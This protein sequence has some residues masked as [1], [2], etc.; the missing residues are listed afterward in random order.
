MSLKENPYDKI[1]QNMREYPNDIPIVEGK[2]SEAFKEY[3]KLMFTPEEAE[4]AQHLEVRP[5]SARAISKRLGKST[6]ETK[7]ILKEMADNG[8]I[9]DIGGYSFFLTVAHL[10]NVGF[11]YSKAYKRLGKKGA[12]LYQQFFIEE[13][14]YKRYESSDTGT[15]LTRVIPIEHSI[16][17]K[18]EISNTEEIHQIIDNCAS[19]I[20]I[21]DCPC[22]K[23]TETLGIRE[24]KDKYPVSESCFQLGAF[25]DYFLKRG[26]GRELSVEEAHELVDKFAKLGLVFTTENVKTP[27]HQVV[28]CCC[29]CCCS[30]LRGVTRFAEKNEN[31]TSKS[32]YISQ[33][34][35]S[36]C[37]GCGLC[38][39][40]CFFKAIEIK[41]NKSS[42]NPSKCFGC[43]VCAVTCPTGAIKLHRQE[44]SHIYS[45]QF[46]LMKKIYQ[47]N[48]INK[49]K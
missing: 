31:C 37:K 36:L 17:I 25:G 45:N 12:E 11:K 13:K 40:R 32:N 20:V 19:P 15:S 7:R 5:L 38:E 42:V 29:G 27:N 26:E 14:Y 44:R 39:R 10:F 34:D 1:L 2:I 9:Q 49:V 28:C 41:N 30:L 16:A 6:K 33:V 23:R 35:Q 24:C 4:V 3:I 48:R 22:R 46:E 43:G 47:E 18:S 21:T 8:I